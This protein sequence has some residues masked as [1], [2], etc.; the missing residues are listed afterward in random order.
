MK[1]SGIY[2]IQSTVKPERIYVGSAVDVKDRW[3]CHLKGL[4]KNKHHSKKL[5]NHF[6]K[7]GESDLIFIIIEQCLP[8]FLIIREQHYIDKMEPYFNTCKIAGNT[9][10]IK[11][12]DESKKKISEKAKG[13]IVSEETR[14]L[15][16]ESGKGE[17]NHFFGKKHS[18]ETRKKI[19]EL[20]KGRKCSD[21]TKRKMSASR[22]GK[23]M[24]SEN[25]MFG[26][27]MFGEDNPMFGKKHTPE[28][29]AKQSAI[30]MGNKYS[31]GH[32]QTEEH[33]RN[34]IEGRKGYKHSPE[35]IQKLRDIQ[36]NRRLKKAI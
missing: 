32:K 16:S 33:K 5:Q 18:E 8:D 13:R 1:N 12:S 9:L 23:S 22:K 14:S 30:M 25:P 20:A 2:E 35:I 31:L 11:F 4:R 3:R 10:G 17:N 21:E 7:Y 24:G 36:A 19:S 34:A 15:L 6:N 27:G 28:Q 29:S 26:K